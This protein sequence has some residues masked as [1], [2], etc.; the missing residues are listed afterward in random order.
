MIRNQD[1]DST[2][3]EMSKQCARAKA[4]RSR[5]QGKLRA[6][7]ERVDKKLDKANYGE[8]V[9]HREVTAVSATAAKHKP[10]SNPHPPLL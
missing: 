1:G 7:L 10:P 2:G 6:L 8:E 4:K 3:Q 5:D 9:P